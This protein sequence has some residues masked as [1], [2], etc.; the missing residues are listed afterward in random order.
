MMATRR[1]GSLL[2]LLLLLARPV[3]TSPEQP[4][5]TPPTPA[6]APPT[7]PPIAPL[8]VAGATPLYAAVVSSSRYWFNYRH[9]S[10]ALAAYR[11]L[12][13]RGVPDSHI[14][15][16]LADDHACDARNAARAARVFSGDGGVG[17]APRADGSAAGARAAAARSVLPADAEVDFAGADVT[18]DA[19]LRALTGRQHAGTPASRRFP[20]E[21]GA[22][23]TLLVFLT[24]HGGDGFLKFH[25]S[26][27]LAYPELAAALADARER[28]RFAR[29][30]IVADTCQAASIG[31]GLADLRP[32]PQQQQRQADGGGRGATGAFAQW[33]SAAA[34]A[35]AGAWAALAKPDEEPEGGRFHTPGVIVAASSRVGQNSYSVGLDPGVGLYLADGFSQALH[36]LLA[37][38][39]RERVDAEHAR[40]LDEDGAGGRG[41][42]ASL[43][44][45]L[46]CAGP[47][48]PALSRLAAACAWL[49]DYGAASGPR[50]GARFGWPGALDALNALAAPAG[51]T[52]AAPTLRALR[53]FQIASNVVLVT[54]AAAL[55]GAADAEE[56]PLL[57]FFS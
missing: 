29:A 10:N 38:E 52:G 26:E 45:E 43:P 20:A 50:A 2:S 42:N 7:R 9:S 15:L 13:A 23:A 49:G 14:L 11:A 21:M 25:D 56:L 16:F 44:L 51:I 1:L 55:S 17:A 34:D 12:R 41:A 47:G 19:L 6:P 22:D 35:A 8:G 37:R 46:A 40:R 28:G 5:L 54:R 24:G 36:D 33:A 53:S 57:P 3:R 30:L 4:A 32:P 27:E 18:A 31:D 39:E 48:P